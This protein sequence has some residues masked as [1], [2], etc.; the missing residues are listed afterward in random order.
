MLDPIRKCR[1]F[2]W[3]VPAGRNSEY[4]QG[5]IC[6]REG[7]ECRI[8]LGDSLLACIQIKAQKVFI[9]LGPFCGNSVSDGRDFV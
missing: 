6:N 4:G 8:R 7:W 2:N 9:V 1:K 3:K 5:D